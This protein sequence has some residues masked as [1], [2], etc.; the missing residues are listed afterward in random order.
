MIVECYYDV[1]QGQ[2][3]YCCYRR[4]KQTANYI[5]VVFNTLLS[6]AENVTK[7]EI[8]YRILRTAKNDEWEK[9]QHLVLHQQ[10]KKRPLNASSSS[11]S[12]SLSSSSGPNT[13]KN[14][15]T[16]TINNHLPTNTSEKVAEAE[17]AGVEVAEEGEVRNGGGDLVSMA[18]ST[19]QES[20][21]MMKEEEE[22]DEEEGVANELKEHEDVKMEDQHFVLEDGEL[23]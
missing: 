11:S 8:M 15:T 16:A 12:T 19:A 21:V 7:D 4:E 1:K 17:T 5:K 22:Q 14:H 2:W 18:P 9:Q 23:A 13:T 6:V 20:D 3:R 10:Q